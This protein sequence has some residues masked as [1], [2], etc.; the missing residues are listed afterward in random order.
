MSYRSLNQTGVSHLIVVLAVVVLGAVGFASYRVM[1]M[2]KPA[3]QDAAVTTKTPAKIQSKTDLEKASKSLDDENVDK[4][5]DSS[6]LDDD[7][8]S[9]L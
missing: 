9:M 4:T 8:N 3:T 1:Q 2:N 7:L 6:Q 5:L